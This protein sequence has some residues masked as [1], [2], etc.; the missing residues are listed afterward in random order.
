MHIF[1][2]SSCSSTANS[3]GIIWCNGKTV[4]LSHFVNLGYD[5]AERRGNEWTEEKKMKA[6][7]NKAIGMYTMEACM[8]TRVMA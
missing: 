7:E 1:V 4:K 5:Y 6:L 2:L 3:G 8:C